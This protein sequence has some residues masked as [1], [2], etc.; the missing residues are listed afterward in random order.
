MQTDLIKL[1]PHFDVIS[2]DIFDT[3]LVRNVLNPKDVWRIMS[4]SEEFEF[5]KGRSSFFEVRDAADRATYAAAT[6]R[7]GE[8]TLDEAYA[9]MGAEWAESN[10]PATIRGGRNEA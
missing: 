7:G 5:E 9:M 4:S 10:R 3:L 1:L 8:H 6:A 2:F